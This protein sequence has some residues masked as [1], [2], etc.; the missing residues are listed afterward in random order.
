MSFTSYPIVTFGSNIDI[1]RQ[2]H[3][4]LTTNL[5]DINGLQTSVKDSLVDAINSLN[6]DFSALTVSAYPP[7]NNEQ[8]LTAKIQSGFGTLNLFKLSS[9]NEFIIGQHMIPLSTVTD[10]GKVSTPWRVGYIS[11]VNTTKI[12]AVSNLEIAATNILTLTFNASQLVLS[13][14]NPVLLT[15]Q[16]SGEGLDIRSLQTRLYS[17]NFL[18]DITTAGHLEPGLT[19]QQ[20]I[21]SASK[22]V[23][24]VFTKNITASGDVTFNADVIMPNAGAA[25]PIGG[26]CLW[27][28]PTIPNNYLIANGQEVSRTTY[29]ALFAIYGI[30]FGAGNGSTTFN[31]PDMRNR[32]PFGVHNAQTSNPDASVPGR[33]FGTLNHTHNVSLPRHYHGPSGLIIGDHVNQITG[34]PSATP[35]ASFSGEALPGH[36]HDLSANNANISIA[37]STTGIT[38]NGS[39]TGVYT[40]SGGEHRHSVPNNS[41]NAFIGSSNRLRCVRG[42]DKNESGTTGPGDLTGGNEGGHGHVIGDPGHS[43]GIS[44]PNGGAGHGHGVNQSAHRHT[45]VDMSAGTPRGSVSLSNTFHTHA[46]PTLTHSIGGTVGN[47]TGF[48][49]DQDQNLIAI[50]TANT[51]P[52]SFCVHFIIRAK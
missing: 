32:V 12:Q 33:T 42:G 36:G 1:I 20:N 7:L 2:A 34:G 25:M 22:E 44:E 52:P 49:G 6:A 46:I 28:M 30:T 21:G 38:V 18:W 10:L 47:I 8:W 5:G 51:N 50:G 15:L 26:G 24:R 16:T 43:H 37:S 48:N 3:N 29:S 11:T 27:F 45:V 23:N 31:L 17:G 41:G 39:F 13:E 9:T 4:L 14:T 19:Q 40:A 35:T